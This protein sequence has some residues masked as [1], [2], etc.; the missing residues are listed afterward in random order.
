[1]KNFDLYAQYYDLLYKDKDYQKEVN[2]IH[3]LISSFAPSKSNL[4]L[5]LGCGTGIHAALLSH[6]GYKIDGLDI[7][8]EMI[9]RANEKFGKDKNLCFKQG[10]IRKFSLKKKYPIV[11]SLFHVMSYQTKNEDLM[12][13]FKNAKKHLLPGGI[14]IFDC[15]HGPGVLTDLPEKRIKNISNSTIEVTREATPDIHF[16]ENIV[17]VSYKIKVVDIR[18]KKDISI[19]ETHKMRYLF[20]PEILMFAELSKMKLLK[21][22]TWLTRKKVENN[23]NVIY[24]LESK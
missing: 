21:S 9:Q 13:V 10:D 11:I 2:Y 15:W 5:E 22:Y 1:M 20:Q 4:V 24:V 18:S 14:F 16:S 7:S 6:K 17:D 19:K 3:S 12:N 23:W 8:P